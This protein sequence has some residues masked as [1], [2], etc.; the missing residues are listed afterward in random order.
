VGPLLVALGLFQLVRVVANWYHAAYRAGFDA[1]NY[2]YGEKGNALYGFLQGG[3][4]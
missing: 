4:P 2:V 3:Q 1:R